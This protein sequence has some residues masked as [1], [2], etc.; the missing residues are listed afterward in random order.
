MREIW[1]KKYPE[2]GASEQ[3]L[4]DQKRV[5]ENHNSCHH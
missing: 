4:L 5:I 2:T 1:Q 3:M